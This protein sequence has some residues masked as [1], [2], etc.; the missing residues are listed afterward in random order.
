MYAECRN[1]PGFAWNHPQSRRRCTSI[2]DRRSRTIGETAYMGRNLQRWG[3]AVHGAQRRP[4]AG[5]RSIDAGASS[6]LRIV[7]ELVHM[8][9]TRHVLESIAFNMDSSN[10][11][12]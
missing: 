5:H 10:E 9:F 4:Q 12:T 8:P 2:T 1:H 6:T 3:T 11:Q 7:Q